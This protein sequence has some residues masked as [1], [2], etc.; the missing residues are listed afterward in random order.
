[1]SM[2]FDGKLEKWNDDRGFGFITPLRGGDPVAVH[3]SAFQADGRRPR[4]GEPLTF[5][6]EPAGDGKRRAINVQRPGHKQLRTTHTPEPRHTGQGARTSWA[7]LA[8]AAA[9]VVAGVYAYTHFSGRDARHA[10]PDAPSSTPTPLYSTP[11]TGAFKCDGRT[12][13]SQMTSCAEATFFLKNCPGA[14][15][16][17][18]GDGIPC[19]KQ[20]CGSGTG[21]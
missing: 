14:Q 9:L 7:G 10:A 2:R 18:N 16:D 4:I 6:V 21:R 15:M 12:R 8:V 20:W 11:A 17:G 1:M 3:I 13:C 19:E 5:E